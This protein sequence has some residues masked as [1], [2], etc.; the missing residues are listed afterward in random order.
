MKLNEHSYCRHVL[1]FLALLNCLMEVN[2][3]PLQ[4]LPLFLLSYITLV[5]Y[6]SP[7]FCMLI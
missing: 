7:S 3:S 4:C 6:L 1:D 5:L 2:P